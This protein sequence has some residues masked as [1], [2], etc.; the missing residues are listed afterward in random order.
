MSP[1]DTTK[2]QPVEAA[3]PI[4]IEPV[5]PAA[6]A[7]PV[8]AAASPLAAETKKSRLPQKDTTS[9]ILSL[10]AVTISAVSLYLTQVY[11]KHA[12][13]FRYIDS[14]YVTYG[15]GDTSP[16]FH[17]RAALVNTGT[18]DAIVATADLDLVSDKDTDHNPNLPSNENIIEPVSLKPGEIKIISV[19]VDEFSVPD[20]AE[21]VDVVL[22][23]KTMDARA[24]AYRIRFP[25]ALWSRKLRQ[26]LVPAPMGYLV[27][28]MRN[29]TV[30]NFDH[31]NTR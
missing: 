3:K 27:S 4:A 7:S 6:S 12:L 10:V 13:V 17:L 1:D 26:Q 29:G 20:D 15:A 11:E 22:D 9:L 21:F 19:G 24:N 8:P 30:K 16:S 25:V 2:N 28:L 14:E 5:P 31:V 23:V 18:R